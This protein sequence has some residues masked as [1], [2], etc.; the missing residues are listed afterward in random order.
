MKTTSL[1]T[2]LA[3]AG[4]SF[5]ALQGQTQKAALTVCMNPD[6]NTLKGVRP[7]ASAVFARIGVKIDWREGDSCPIGLGVIHVRLSYDSPRIGNSD[8]AAFSWPYEGSIVVFVDR[9]RKLNRYGVQSVMAYVLVHEITHVLEGIKRHSATGIMKA[10]WDDN[11]YF[12]MSR[13]TLFFAQE[14]VDLI[15]DGLKARQARVG[16]P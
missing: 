15:Y 12:E 5:S 16:L 10:R 2:L 8:A 1:V 3:M 4:A 14:D 7:T 13:R 9:V 11:D 6:P